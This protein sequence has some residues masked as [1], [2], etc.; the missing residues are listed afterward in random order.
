MSSF[1]VLETVVRCYIGYRVVLYL[2]GFRRRDKLKRSIRGL[3]FGGGHQF[4]ITK[5]ELD[6]A[7]TNLRRTG[8]HRALSTFGREH[9]KRTKEIETAKKNLGRLKLLKIGLRVLAI[10]LVA[11]FFFSFNESWPSSPFLVDDPA[12]EVCGTAVAS[13]TQQHCVSKRENTFHE[14]LRLSVATAKFMAATSIRT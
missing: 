6:T 14:R 2:F 5:L 1:P 12:V 9:A 10:A 13:S 7:I 3:A 4:K 11:A 8:S